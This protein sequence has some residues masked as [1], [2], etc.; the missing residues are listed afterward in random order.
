MSNRRYK[1]EVL[2]S[3]SI[4]G[5]GLGSIEMMVAVGRAANF[6]AASQ[7]A[8]FVSMGTNGW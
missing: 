1:A 3:A 2:N 5:D 8:G 6:A 4:F 7:T